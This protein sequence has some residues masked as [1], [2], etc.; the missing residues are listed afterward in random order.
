MGME[1]LHLKARTRRKLF[2]SLLIMMLLFVVFV[3]GAS[4]RWN[5]GAFWTRIFSW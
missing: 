2:W 3:T 1:L 4:A 5:V